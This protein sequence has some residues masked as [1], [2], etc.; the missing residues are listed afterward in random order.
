MVNRI[1][2]EQERASKGDVETTIQE[3][4]GKV[5]TAARAITSRLQATLNITT[6]KSQ[7][8]ASW[9][10]LVALLR[11]SMLSQLTNLEQSGMT[12]NRAIAL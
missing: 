6:T 4:E 12:P 11:Q 3:G 5:P 7:R 8:L 2:M 10:L 9:I 1:G